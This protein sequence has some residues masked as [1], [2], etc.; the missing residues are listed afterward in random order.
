M[1]ALWDLLAD[2]D[3]TAGVLVTSLA[4]VAVATALRFLTAALARRRLRDDPYRRYWAGKVATYVFTA[5]TFVVLVVLWAPLG[6]RISVILGFATAGIAF[7]MQEV[8]GALFG[9]VNV[10]AG[11]IYNVGDRIE[12]GGVRGDVL[13]ITPLRT[14]LLEIGGAPRGGEGS[15]SWVTARQPTGR[16]VAISNKKTFTD[17]VFNYSAQLEWIWE[18]LT[19]VVS[20]DADWQRAEAILLEEVRGESPAVREQGERTLARLHER[21]RFSA[22][23]VEPRVFVRVV[24]GDIELTARFVVGVRRARAA[25]DAITRRV[26]EQLANAGIALAY[27]TTALTDGLQ[28][29]RDH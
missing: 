10:L 6:G 21:H 17:A 15:G 9:W 23:D 1:D 5:V 16:V 11:R 14:T 27:P 25:K 26:L 3:S 22:G 13:D 4:V 29:N 8:I 19:L 7:A 24:E 20:Q 18:E 2:T 12:V 28:R